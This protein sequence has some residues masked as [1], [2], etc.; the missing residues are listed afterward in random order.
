MT[1]A[2]LSPSGDP[3]GGGGGGGRTRKVR[4]PAVVGKAAEARAL[5]AAAR[6]RLRRD[7]ASRAAR[8]GQA[9]PTL[10]EEGL[11]DVRTQTRGGISS[12]SSSSSSSSNDP[13][14]RGMDGGGGSDISDIRSAI[15]LNRLMSQEED[16]ESLLRMV[17]ADLPSFNDVN[18]ATALSKLGGALQVEQRLTLG[19][20]T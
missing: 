5:G 7:G 2:A 1:R 8:K 11:L 14:G 6:E 13:G 9:R 4:R 3:D 10:D 15:A 17:A 18:V 19:L 20:S 16:P 12:S